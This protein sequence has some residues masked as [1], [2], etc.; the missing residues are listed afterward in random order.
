[1]MHIITVLTVG[2]VML[3]C[4]LKTPESHIRLC[5]FTVKSLRGRDHTQQTRD[6]STSTTQKA[7]G[8][9]ELFVMTS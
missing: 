3:S 8:A 9:P 4:H 6:Q 2:G 5:P 1:M 7:R